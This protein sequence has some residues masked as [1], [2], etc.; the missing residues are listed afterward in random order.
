MNKQEAADLIRRY[1]AGL[2]TN[3]EK[4]LVESWY[5]QMELQDLEDMPASMRAE[6]LERI[7]ERLL[8]QQPRIRRIHPLYRVAIAAAV[9]ML[10][11]TSI[12]FFIAKPAPDPVTFANTL[13]PGKNEAVITLGNGQQLIL[14]AVPEGKLATQ[15]NTNITKTAN[16]QIV[17]KGTAAGSDGG[18]VYN[19]LTTPAGGT[20]TLVLSDHTVI[21]LDAGSSIRYPVSFY[22]N[23]RQVELTGQAYFDVAQDKAHPF[24]VISNK[25]VTEVLGTRF[26]INAYADE[27]AMRTTLLQGRI[28]VNSGR[29]S[30][31]LNPGQESVISAN[32]AISV[33]EADVET[34][35]AWKNGIFKFRRADLQ[36]VMRQFSRWYNV[37]V[38]Y[39]GKVPE[40]SITGKIQRNASA[41]EMLKIIS[42]LG[43]KFKT[44]GQKI[45]I[46]GE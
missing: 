12:Y 14:S 25:Q 30:V 17:Y 9:L 27:S 33:T 7:G 26:N 22:G 37:E 8:I 5:M 29:Q 34:V 43:V 15:D 21:T 3:A 32:T 28:R 10:I 18:E 4:E 41:A 2:C 45:I 38:V 24:K 23:E 31:I 1:N 36:S 11:A 42:D 40:A 46:M 35:M 16:G 44:D 6:D 20:Y 19:T 39:E 13:R